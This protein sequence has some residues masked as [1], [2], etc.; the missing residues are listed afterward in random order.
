MQKLSD[1]DVNEWLTA[2]REAANKAGDLY[3]YAVPPRAEPEEPAK[4]APIFSKND[5]ARLAMAVMESK[6]DVRQY[7]ARR[8][9]E[10][11]EDRGETPMQKIAAKFND[12]SKIFDK[13]ELAERHYMDKHVL[14]DIDVNPGITHSPSILYPGPALRWPVVS[15][16]RCLLAELSQ[17]QCHSQ[18][19]PE[20]LHFMQCDTPCLFSQLCLS[21]RRYTSRC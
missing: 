8:K 7:E 4:G 21:I 2:A 5:T 13:V 14:D 9:R 20:L 18:K 1:S 15:A 6:E 17:R 10:N 12:T 11:F 16:A 3:G 19:V